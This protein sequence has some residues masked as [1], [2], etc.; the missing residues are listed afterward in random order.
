TTEDGEPFPARWP[1]TA[2]PREPTEGPSVAVGL[3]NSACSV[4]SVRYLPSRPLPSLLLPSG[5]RTYGGLAI[6][7]VTTSG[8][9]S[10]STSATTGGP[11]EPEPTSG[12]S[13]VVSMAMGTGH[14]V[15]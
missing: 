14:P 1:T 11:S 4:A 13:S 3:L 6:D 15:R 9:P 12:R 5:V 2:P 7:A 8:F 10:P